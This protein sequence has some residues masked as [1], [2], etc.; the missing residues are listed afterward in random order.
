MKDPHILKEVIEVAEQIGAGKFYMKN[1][2]DKGKTP[3]RKIED[4]I[5]SL[6]QKMQQM[7][8]NYASLTSAIA[9]QD[10][11]PSRHPIPRSNPHYVG[12]E[13]RQC[14]IC[15]KRGHLAYNC[16]TKRTN[17]GVR[18]NFDNRE[19]R[20]VNIAWVKTD[21]EYSSEEE[22]VYT[23]IRAHPMPYDMNQ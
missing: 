10:N 8:L 15:G 3:E 13:T 19:N 4:D 17:H 18:N 14:Y 2:L 21:N 9:T 7:L 5:N 20:R 16:K 1:K 12:P 22:Q 23:G 11:Y 6:T